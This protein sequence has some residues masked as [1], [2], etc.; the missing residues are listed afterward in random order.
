MTAKPLKDKKRFQPTQMFEKK[1][2][3]DP[4]MTATKETFPKFE[5][6]EKALPTEVKC[7]SL[8]AIC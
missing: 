5:E 1:R 8:I 6:E 3:M 7:K 2:V 4:Y